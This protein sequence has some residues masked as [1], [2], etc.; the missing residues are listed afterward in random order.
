MIQNNADS[1][2]DEMILFAAFALATD[3][4]C[5]SLLNPITS[6]LER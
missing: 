6:T 5:R 3:L 2:A 1:E 4:S